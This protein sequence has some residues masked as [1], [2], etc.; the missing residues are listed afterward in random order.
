MR[1]VARMA[2]VSLSTVSRVVSGRQVAPEM[3][4][5]VT[6]AVELLGYRHDAVAGSLRNARR[7]SASIGLIVEDVSNPFFAAI[8]RGAED[9]ARERAM[10]TFAG[11]S[12]EQ[13]QQER[14]LAEAFLVRRVDGLIIAPASSDHSYLAR[15][16]HAGLALVFVDRPPQFI[17]ADAVLTDN[18]GGARAAVSHLLAAGHRRVA[19]IG[20][21]SEIF[22]GAQRLEGYRLALSERGIPADPALIRH[23]SFRAT[24][25]VAVTESL[26]S[27]PAPP[28]ALFTAQNLITVEAMRRLH[29]LELHRS[30]AHVGFDD[31]PLA[32]VVEPGVTVVA[33]DP[34]AMGRRAAELLFSRLDGYAGPSRRVVLPVSL[35]ERGSGRIPPPAT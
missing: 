4:R 10:L 20:D 22:T 18:V 16:V 15:D 30:V 34:Y 5:R 14:Q 7:S 25:A 28:T 33:Q 31:V 9:A 21:D 27:M 11:S 12:D 13:P 24:D 8:Y 3:A 29:Q 6:R 1:D 19:F 26:L 2:D 17:D 32:D 35:V 23:V